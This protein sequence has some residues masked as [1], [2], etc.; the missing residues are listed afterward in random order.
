MPMLQHYQPKN[1]GS[2]RSTTEAK[3]RPIDR[4]QVATSSPSAKGQTALGQ[5][6]VIIFGRTNIDSPSEQSSAE[7]QSL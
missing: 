5:D 6:G 2:R 4:P 7:L 3:S 1:V